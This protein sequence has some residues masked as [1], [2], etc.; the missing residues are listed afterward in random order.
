MKGGEKIAVSALREALDVKPPAEAVAHLNMLVYGDPGVGK[1]SL[2]AT[3][4][5][6]EET[7]PVLFLDVEGGT[8]TIRK[9]SDIDVKRVQSIQ[10]VVEVHQLLREDNDGYY[11][12]CIIDSLS[13]LQKLDMR[14]IMRELV[15]RR[16]DMD[17]D[18]PSQREWGKS[19][20]HIRRIVRA[21]RD[22]PMHTIFTALV[23]IDKDENG[24][25]TYEPLLPGKLK[26]E[27]PG[28]F[29]IVG[30]MS[31]V[32][33]NDEIVRRIQFVQTKRVKAK[34]RTDS[35]GDKVDFPTIPL[36]WQKINEK[37]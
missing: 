17:P 9:R 4:Q 31:A 37:G 19:G 32:H 24:V 27:I 18:V 30:Y 1:T 16:P 20:E 5:D 28:F 25:V 15:Q 26:K 23:N 35:L 11:K 13:E 22:L 10:D 36:L 34:D 3:A 12:T 21:Y 14:D 6:N 33:E 8:T 29:D 2:A 7:S